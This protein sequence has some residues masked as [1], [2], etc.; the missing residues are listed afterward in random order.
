MARIKAINTFFAKNGYRLMDSSMYSQPIQTQAQYPS[1]V[2]MQPVY[3]P[4][5]QY[6]VYSILPQSW[7]PSPAPYF[8]TP[9]VSEILTA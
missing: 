7:S 8:E 5:Q 6:S 3:S 9:L 1:P 2:F 4:H